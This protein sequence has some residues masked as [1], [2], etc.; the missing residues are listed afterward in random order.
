[1]VDEI[2]KILNGGYDLHL[3]TSPDIFPRKLNDIDA[4]L[5]AKEAGLKGIVLKNHFSPT[6][7][8]AQIASEKT[9]FNV[10]GSIT[11]NRTVGGLNPEA[12]EAALRS[13]A[14]IVWMPTIHSLKTVSEP[15]MVSMF[16]DVV[17][18]E[19]GGVPIVK[20]GKIVSELLPILSLIKEKDVT[21][22]TG[23]IYPNE[24]VE[25]VREAVRIGIKKIILTHPFSCLVEM[26]F[27]HVKE[28]L[29]L[30]DG[31]FVEFTCFDCSSLIKRPLS[32]ERAAELIK[33]VTPHRAIISSDGGQSLNPMPTEMLFHMIKNLLK[34]F[35]F[36]DIRQMIVHNP[37]YLIS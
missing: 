10:I 15:D 32:Y 16:K 20:D 7:E 35:T 30:S 19:K 3:H 4:A 37:S 28:L 9:D 21:L 11:L 18:A 8:R 25:L 34:N 29:S 22:A 26:E 6:S 23:H 27:G 1:M 33:E 17:D 13:G 36:Q 24:A 12:V 5:F 31:I 2:K 14:R